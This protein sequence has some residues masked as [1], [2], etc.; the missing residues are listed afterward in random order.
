MLHSLLSL[1][2]KKT[3][4][5]ATTLIMKVTSKTLVGLSFFFKN[6]SLCHYSQLLDIAAEDTPKHT[7][8]FRVNYIFSSVVYANKLLVTLTAHE[9][10]YLP[11]LLTIFFSAG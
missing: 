6:H 3:F 9:L 2:I 4:V 8:R 5:L 10:Q 1:I 11:S 7:N